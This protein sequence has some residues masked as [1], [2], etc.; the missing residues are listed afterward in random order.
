MPHFVYLLIS[1]GHLACCH[2]LAIMDNVVNICE[3]VLM[4]TYIFSRVIPRSRISGSCGKS[5]FNY[6]RTAKLFPTVA[7]SL[8]IPTRS[9]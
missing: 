1:C 4:W 9:V 5:M 2:F 7:I 6:L 8:Y 3:Q